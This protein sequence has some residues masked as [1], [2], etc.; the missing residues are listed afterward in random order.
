MPSSPAVQLRS[1]ARRA[2]EGAVAP[3]LPT[4]TSP[5][6]AA[7]RPGRA[8]AVLP[9][10][11]LAGALAGTLLVAITTAAL[12]W[13][14]AAAPD[15]SGA[16]RP[17]HAL[18][19]A[20]VAGASP[21]ACA[22]ALALPRVALLFLTQGPMPHSPTWRLWF[23]VAAGL[24]PAPAL[25]EACRPKAALA[26]A[27]D[28]LAA[29][30]AG[31]GGAAAHPAA[32]AAAAGDAIAR[33]HLFSVYVH[34]PPSFPGHRGPG[35]AA[36]DAANAS[37]LAQALWAGRLVRGR[38]ATGWGD[39]S[40]VA[41]TR[42]LLWEAYRDPLNTRWGGARRGGGGR[43]GGGGAEMRAQHPFAAAAPAPLRA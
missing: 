42:S 40:L 14:A 28:L 8:R 22:Q 20:E 43:A 1:P 3:L 6:A 2:L 11:L 30:A 13:P 12:R 34:A 16:A 21:D 9:G 24:L 32:A 26:L 10:A 41:A 33:Q 37:S 25:R 36:G 4:S 38:L 19:P 35:A 27:P 31:A 39:I 5:L 23:E 29:C 15:A 7:P 18:R 17:F